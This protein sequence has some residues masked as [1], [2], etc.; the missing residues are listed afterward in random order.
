[1][2]IF[3]YCFLFFIMEYSYL[4]KVVKCSIKLISE[5]IGYNFWLHF[6]HIYIYIVYQYIRN[7][8]I[9]LYYYVVYIYLYMTLHYT[10][11]IPRKSTFRFTACN[12][13]LLR[14]TA[15]SSMTFP[16]VCASRNMSTKPAMNC[17]DMPRPR[18]EL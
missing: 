2:I 10:F 12:Q 8:E 11:T 9:L 16:L 3:Y 15:R 17:C 1:M 7:I 4:K 14:C 5:I 13:C 18:N 6:K